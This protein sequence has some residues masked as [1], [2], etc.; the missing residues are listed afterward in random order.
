MSGNADAS[1]HLSS[2]GKNLDAAQVF[3]DYAKDVDSAVQVLSKGLEFAEAQR[4]V[5]HLLSP[6]TCLTSR[7]L[8]MIDRIS[9]N[10]PFTLGSKMR[11]R[12]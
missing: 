1:D 3:M 7:P 9:L 10:R 12:N 11:M 4:L 6:S 5:C 2:R 8:Y